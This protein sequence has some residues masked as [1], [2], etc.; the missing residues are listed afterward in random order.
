MN[1]TIA[2]LLT[3]S[4]ILLIPPCLYGFYSPNLAIK[5][6]ALVLYIFLSVTDFL[7]GYY[8]RISKTESKLGAILDP[9]ADKWFVLSS[10]IT[11]L[12]MKILKGLPILLIFITLFRET[13]VIGLRNIAALKKI[14]IPSSL[15]GKMKTLLQMFGLNFLFLN[16]S[17]KTPCPLVYQAGMIML[18]LGTIFSLISCRQY[19]RIFSKT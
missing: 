3:T 17:I 7:D 10:M 9:L 19:F 18:I 14:D 12:D 11:L 8:A 2:D 4:R 6:S 15:S 1:L 5:K 13:F 16:I